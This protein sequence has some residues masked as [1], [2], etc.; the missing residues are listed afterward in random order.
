MSGRLRAEGPAIAGLLAVVL[1]LFSDV[2]F[3]G[4][5]FYDRDIHLEWYSQMEGFVRAVAAGSWPLWDSTIAFGQPLLADPSAQIAYP[6]TWLNLV[7]LPWDYYT[8]FVVL[9]CVATGVGMFLLARHLGTSRLAAFTAAGIWMASGPLLSLVNVWHHFAG[10]CWIP[11]VALAAARAVAR[12]AGVPRVLLWGLAEALQILAGS[13]EMAAMGVAASVVVILADL[14]HDSPRARPPR[15]VLVRSGLAAIVAVGLSSLLWMPTLDLLMGSSRSSLSES[16]RTTWSVPPLALAR[17]LL[18]LPFLDLPLKRVWQE[19]LFDSVPPFLDSLYLG[20][21]TL[22]LALGARGSPHRTLRRVGI[23]LFLVAIALALGRHAPFYGVAV[24]VFPPLAI[25]RYP[26]KVMLLAAFAWALLVGGGVDEE[27]G[28]AEGRR[29]SGLAGLA[30]IGVL[31]AAA[32]AW[33]WW[34]PTTLVPF[35]AAASLARPLG[36]IVSVLVRRVRALRPG[37]ARGRHPAR[38][39]SGTTAELRRGR[40]RHGLRGRPHRGSPP[41]QSHDGP[42]AR[43][44]PPPHPGRPRQRGPSPTLC[45]RVFPEPRFVPTVPGPGRSLR[46]SRSRGPRVEP[47]SGRSLP[48]ASILSPRWPVVGA[49]KGASTWTLAVSTRARSRASSRSCTRPREPLGTSVSFVWAPCGGSSPFTPP[50][51]KSSNSRRPCGASSP[52]R[53]GASRCRDPLPRSYAVGAVRV[54]SGQAALD[55]LGDP[56]FDPAREVVLSSAPIDPPSLGF[57]GSTRIVELVSDRVRIEAHLTA[58]GYVVLVDA[59][60]PGWQATLDGVAVEVLRANTAFR[61]VRAPAGRHVIEYTYRP[62]WL[63]R[64]L[65][66]SLATALG[67]LAI[68]F[69]ATR[70]AGRGGP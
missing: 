43:R 22:A 17:T 15:E 8:V 37:A 66:V 13:S 29:R 26:S 65:A 20:L 7:L 3:G 38:R 56:S 61:A 59:Y 25:F 30:V 6:L 11:W 36:G 31:V 47:P 19:R 49:S 16:M 24:R 60:D 10:A 35:L 70:R 18:P 67:S 54:A 53:S 64:G 4:R 2:M 5:V 39:G 1:V 28:P 69:V 63:M 46:H 45:L 51:S 33:V 55:L 50:D 44:V 32:G 58:P 23:V 42:R 21:P 41:A 52:S 62:T 57:S 14:S 48:N 9:H 12:G 40:D 34:Q 68:A 27:G